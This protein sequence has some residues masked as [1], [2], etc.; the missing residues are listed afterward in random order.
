MY[1]QEKK[2]KELMAVESQVVAD[3]EMENRLVAM[4]IKKQQDSVAHV[5]RVRCQ[6]GCCVLLWY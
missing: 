5:Q 1:I 4:A 3:K 2:K 6:Y